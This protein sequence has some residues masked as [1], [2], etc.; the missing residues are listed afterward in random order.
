MIG[1]MVKKGFKKDTQRLLIEIAGDEIN[2]LNLLYDLNTVLINHSKYDSS[3]RK[4]LIE[5]N[6]DI[7]SKLT[8][9]EK[10]IFIQESF[11]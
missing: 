7:I 5:Y 9:Q 3:L 1:Y 2:N 6:D 8:D 10:D 4:H 11:F